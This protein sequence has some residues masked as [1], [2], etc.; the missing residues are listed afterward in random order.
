[1]AGGAPRVMPARIGSHSKPAGRPAADDL[2]TANFAGAT[3]RRTLSSA[4]CAAHAARRRFKARGTPGPAD[5]GHVPI[6]KA[7]RMAR[8][9]HCQE[10]VATAQCR[11]APNEPQNLA[12]YAQAA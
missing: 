4:C 7:S 3:W 5:A 11:A 10:P 9:S 12:D 1:M 2:A 6:V 8:A